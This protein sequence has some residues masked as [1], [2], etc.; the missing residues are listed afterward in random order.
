MKLFQRGV[1]AVLNKSSYLKMQLTP[2]STTF[3]VHCNKGMP[4]NIHKYRFLCMATL[5]EIEI[6]R[7]WR[8]V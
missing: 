3:V 2:T 7:D 8:S 1:F 6:I 4:E 5:Q